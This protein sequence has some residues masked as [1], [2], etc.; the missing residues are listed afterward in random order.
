MTGSTICTRT[1][2]RYPSD[3]VIV[4][5]GDTVSLGYYRQPELTATA[6]LLIDGPNGRERAYRTGDSG[7]LADGWLFFSG[8]LDFQ[9]KLHGYRIEIEDIEANLQRLPEVQRA[10]VMAVPRRDSP[11]TVLHL[12]AAVQLRGPLPDNPLRTTLHLKA[13]L[14]ELLP[15]YMVPKV[16]SYVTDIPLTANG[17]ADRSKLMAR[18]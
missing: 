8:R 11:G 7:R 2:S 13:Q 16:F 4:I 10:V 5:A 17:K 14:R 18:R 6:F 12:K 15:D 3:A 9:V 1:A